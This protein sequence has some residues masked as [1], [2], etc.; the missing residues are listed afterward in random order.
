MAFRVSRLLH[1]FGLVD[2]RWFTDASR[3]RGHHV[4][5]IAEQVFTGQ[6]S[7][8]VGAGYVAYWNAL[9]GAA[10]ALSAKMICVER[11]LWGR[12]VTGRPDAVGWLET[13]VGQHLR[14]GPVIIDIKS[15]APAAAHGLQLAWYAKLADET[16]LRHQLPS[17][18]EIF[19]WQRVCVH[20]GDDGRYHLTP[21]TNVTDAAICDAI[22]DVAHWRRQHGYGCDDVSPDRIFDDDPEVP[23]I[24]GAAVSTGG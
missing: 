6:Q 13:S 22:V 11:R 17:H 5:T 4:H 21:Y 9:K 24:A 1:E 2:S 12:D 23:G 8:A 3:E 18:Y 10:K 20:V 16:G 19:P 7:L 14:P 15:G